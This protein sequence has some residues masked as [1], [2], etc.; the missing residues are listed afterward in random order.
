MTAEATTTTTTTTTNP[1]DTVQAQDLAEIQGIILRGYKLEYARHFVLQILNPAAFKQF[2]AKLIPGAA[3]GPLT[4]T[5][6]APWPGPKPDYFLNIAFSWAGIQALNLPGVTFGGQFEFQAF[7]AGAVAR[8]PQVGDIGASAP[9][10]WLSCLNPTNAPN[11][12]VILTLYAASPK[13]LE[14]RTTTLRSMFTA[15]GAA[16]AMTFNDGTTPGPD[17]FDAE[18]LPNGTVHFGYKDGISQPHVEGMPARRPDQQPDLPAWGVVMRQSNSAPYP[19]PDPSIFSRNSGIAAFRILEQDVV[20]F[21]QYVSNQPGVDPEL[22]KAKFCGRW[23]NGNPL[24]LC[25]VSPG[26]PLPP[27]Q[28]SNFSYD[29]D[30]E[31]DKTPVGAHTRRGN[32]RGSE[33]APPYPYHRIVRRAMPYGPP[34]KQG[35][36]D[37]SAKRGLV[38]Y[39]V[40]TSLEQMFEFIMRVWL[41]GQNFAVN[42]TE[43]QGVD[44]LLGDEDDK[45]T[46]FDFPPSG[47]VSGFERFVTTRGGMYCVLPSIPALQW[48]SQQP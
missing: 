41:N 33:S 30:T 6:S 42:F 10:N 35:S 16:Q 20:G 27:S 34:Y 23:S 25:P 22:L 36:N 9:A 14:A 1:Q 7:K 3:A 44:P 39:F 19:L 15:G 46:V 21:D 43:P 5:T 12:H 29:D 13:V 4:I 48:M 40:G 45:K 47:H 2:L 32:P 18:A 38:G 26:A 17:H 37:N 28:L 24:A 31:G 11:A 8:A